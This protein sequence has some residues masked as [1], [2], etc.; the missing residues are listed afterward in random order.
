[1]EGLFSFPIIQFIAFFLALYSIDNITLWG[2]PVSVWGC[3]R[4]CTAPGC[5]VFREFSW[6]FLKVQADMGW[7][8]CA[9]YFSPLFS[10]GLVFWR[11]WR[12]PSVGSHRCCL[13]VSLFF[14]CP[15]GCGRYFFSP[16]LWCFDDPQ[17]VFQWLVWV[18]TK[19]LIIVKVFYRP[20]CWGFRS[21]QTW[22]HSPRSPGCLLL[23]LLWWIWCNHLSCVCLTFIT[24]TWMKEN[25]Q[26]SLC[27]THFFSFAFSIIHV[28]CL[29]YVLH[30]IF[31]ICNCGLEPY[32]SFIYCLQHFKQPCCF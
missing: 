18:K 21:P 29:S 20:W 6:I 22:L 23:H 24:I 26:T 19:V 30:L 9:V 13:E 25:P 15:L 32:L 11:S 1:M 3:W 4:V 31:F 10:W 2:G 8:C 28:V 12:R 17:L 14:L 5:H 27:K 16:M 7:K